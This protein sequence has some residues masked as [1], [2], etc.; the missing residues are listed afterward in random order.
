V[1]ISHSKSPAQA[2]YKNKLEEAQKRVAAK[3]S[4]PP[5]LLSHADLRE[6]YGI[7]YSRVHLHRLMREGKFPR[8]VAFGPEMYC[9]KVWRR[10]A[11]EQWIASLSTFTGSDGAA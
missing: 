6:H 2:K 4:G 10:G 11:I 5:M 7:T 3:H 9:R 8:Q 1:S